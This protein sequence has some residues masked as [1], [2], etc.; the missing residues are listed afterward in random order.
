MGGKTG[1]IRMNKYER[2]ASV[3]ASEGF[4]REDVEAAVAAALADSPLGGGQEVFESANP[5]VVALERLCGPEGYRHLQALAEDITSRT[6]LSVLCIANCDWSFDD[7]C[8]DEA[9]FISFDVPSLPDSYRTDYRNK[10]VPTEV[11]PAPVP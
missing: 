7:E 10:I 5:G 4:V 11:A 6:G 9:T 2:T 3:E 8:D 1:E